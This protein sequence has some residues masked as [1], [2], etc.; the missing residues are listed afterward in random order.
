M[1]D[2]S[3]DEPKLSR[4]LM[5]EDERDQY[6]AYVEMGKIGSDSSE[7]G[8]VIEAEVV[9]DLIQY[10]AEYPDGSTVNGTLGPRVQQST[11]LTE[12]GLEQLADELIGTSID[13][14]P[15]EYRER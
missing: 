4:K 13:P 7:Q 14:L 10:V 11:R 6:E 8:E 5:R 3:S 9:G 12:N 2:D 1:S 15:A